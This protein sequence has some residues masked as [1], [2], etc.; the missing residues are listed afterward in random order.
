MFSM[1]LP[2]EAKIFSAAAKAIELAFECTMLKKP[3]YNILD[4]LSFIQ[5][6]HDTNIDYP[7]ISSLS[8]TYH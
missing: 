4:S 7:Y 8:Y 5:S 6:L 3:F 1:R 2:D